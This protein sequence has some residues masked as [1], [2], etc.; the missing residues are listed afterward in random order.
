M[1]HISID[2]SLNL[3]APKPALPP[4]TP[5]PMPSQA[6]SRFDKSQRRQPL[7][8]HAKPILSRL[9]VFG[10]GLMLTGYG[11]FEMYGVVSVSSVTILQWLLVVLFTINFSWIALAFS[12]SL[13]GFGSL[14]A[15]SKPHI[16]PTSLKAKTALV[17]PVYNEA[18]SR[19]F[20]ALQAMIEEVESTGLLDHYDVFVLSDTT[21]PD[22]WV[23][24]ERTFLAM[25][26]RL[27][28]VNLYYRHRPRNIGRKS[29]NIE[30]FVTRWGGGYE[31]MLVLDA[32]SVM[33]GHCITAL[34]AAMESD[35]D[36][37]IIQ[38][39]PLVTNRNTLFARLQ[40]FAAR[41]YGPVI[42]TGLAIWSGREGNYWGH[43]AIIRVKAF[44][45]HAG[46]PT[47]SGKPPFG[48]HI[49]SHDFVE[50][51]LIRRAGWS[52]YMLPQLTGSYE[53]SPPS[54]IDLSVRDRRWCQGNLQHLRVIGAKGL[55]WSTRQHFATGIMSYLA[56][57]FW[58]AQLLVGM[59]LVLQTYWV[60]PEYFT[61]Q[62]SLFP[63]WPR[64]DAQRALH[65]FE[66]TMAIL[67]AP[68]VFGLFLTLI[69]PPERRACGGGIALIVS[70]CIEILISAL[71]APIMMVIQSGAV[72]QIL[73]GRDTGWNP[74]RRDDGSIPFG[75][76]IKR[77]R[78]HV[79]MGLVAGVTAYLISPS[80]FG[81]MSPTIVGLV[82]SVPLSAASSSLALVLAL[83]R[84]NLLLTPEEVSVPPVILRANALM[85]DYQQSNF[86]TADGLEALW[87]DKVLQQAHIDM[88]PVFPRRHR[89]DI[90][91]DRAI[92]EAK[93]A[94]A[95]ILSDAINWL[96]PKERSLVLSDRALIHLVTS[97]PQSRNE[98]TSS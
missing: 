51:A 54:L 68:K 15:K 35:P 21:D 37:G 19:I 81:W 4:E 13:L 34:T 20:A 57:P 7:V 59:V 56:S 76:V 33:T 30:D 72:T 69:R 8:R 87:I 27:P 25:R 61:Q 22:I 14:L 39:L 41:I 89:G 18:P 93:L 53:E 75:S 60:R 94:D 67:L 82:L 32:D 16:T 12:S 85:K 70:T 73:L 40:Q 24:E 63:A 77:H 17:M 10:G 28:Q 23:A 86:D 1:T 47:L 55:T 95:E 45:D 5:L 88:L 65:L 64:F 91:S 31:H 71:V 58:L 97:L 3:S 84:M 44:A 90:D 2:T 6:L 83:K 29:G 49:L 62:F 80:L 92:A 98:S 66:L 46:L 48:G 50:A 52:V 78:W 96:R 42:A 11:A 43:N 38:S 26:S 79:V 9:F 36:S 74:Q